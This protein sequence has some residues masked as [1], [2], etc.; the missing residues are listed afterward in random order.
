MRKTILVVDDEKLIRQQ[1]NTLFEKYGFSCYQ[2]GSAREARQILQQEK[3]DLAT[4]DV[5]M[6]GENGIELTKWI[7]TT[8]NIPVIMLTSLDDNIDTVVGLEIGA[9]DYIAK[10]FDP[11]VLLARVNAV[12]RRYTPQDGDEIT[13]NT[14]FLNT[15]ER[16]LRNGNNKI[17]LN[18]REYQFIKLL[19]EANSK[20]V[21][22]DMLSKELFHKEW[23]PIDRAIDNFV[24]RLRQKI[25]VNPNTPQYIVTVRQIGYMIPDG[26]IQLHS[27]P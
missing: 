19:I 7:R 15:N 5:I 3:I 6:P 10:P 24:A 9:D 20:S 17:F 25:E 11:R 22:R 4:V 23:N 26:R 8:I 12:I 21:S 13:A 27:Y 14:L 18:E 1:L 16:C 2:A